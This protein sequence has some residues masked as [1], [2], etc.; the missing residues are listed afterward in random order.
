MTEAALGQSA[1]MHRFWRL[2]GND[3][4]A[5]IRS[6]L[7]EHHACGIVGR[8]AKRACWVAASLAMTV[9]AACGGRERGT[10]TGGETSGM[11]PTVLP[12][13]DVPEAD[14]P[15]ADASECDG[16]LCPTTLATLPGAIP[17]AIA[18]DETRVYFSVFA[19]QQ[20]CGAAG[21]T[22]LALNAPPIA[23]PGAIQSVLR[24]GGAVQTL[25]PSNS[26][27]GYGSIAS[28]GTNLY[29]TVLSNSGAYPSLGAV[30]SGAVMKTPIG[31]GAASTVASGQLY[32]TGVIAD[33]QGVYWTDDS[34]LLQSGT[35][36]GL[37]A[38][39][40]TPVTVASGQ[41]GLLDLAASATQVVWCADNDATIMGVQRPDGPPSCSPVTLNAARSQPT[42]TVSISTA[43]TTTAT[44][45]SK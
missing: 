27:L 45:P 28:D 9:G 12:E 11:T 3:P 35:V 41:N 42:M 17:V 23:E 15:G 8:M 18:I 19:P 30:A 43:T 40:T 33:A 5:R 20:Q 10:D 2:P 38:G 16:S 4:V 7:P 34:Q 37:P 13:A 21:C 24:G 39:A 6:R 22:F 44:V 36:M 29:W 25:V 26:A 31:G 32:P 14:V 1:A